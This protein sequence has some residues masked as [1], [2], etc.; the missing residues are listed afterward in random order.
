MVQPGNYKK[1]SSETVTSAKKAKPVATILDAG[2]NEMFS[3]LASRK[4]KLSRTK[5]KVAMATLRKLEREEQADKEKQ[6]I[7]LNFFKMNRLKEIRAQFPIM[8]D[9]EI[10]EV[11]PDFKD[12]IRF[13][14]KPNV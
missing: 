11:F 7:E 6:R 9:D 13:V 4:E 10:L 3:A 14:P 12:L 8:E 1:I 2:T 5:E